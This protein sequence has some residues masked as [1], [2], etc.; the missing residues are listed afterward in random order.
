MTIKRAR[1]RE[2]VSVRKSNLKK[3]NENIQLT[4]SCGLVTLVSGSGGISNK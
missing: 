4:S 1:S 2:N 3:R